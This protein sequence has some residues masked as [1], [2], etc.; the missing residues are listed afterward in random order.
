MC[1]SI[2]PSRFRREEMRRERH[3]DERVGPVF[4]NMTARSDSTRRADR[5]M[6]AHLLPVPRASSL[7]FSS[8]SA[9]HKCLA[10]CWSPVRCKYSRRRTH[11]D[12]LLLH[13]SGRMTSTSPTPGRIKKGPGRRGS[14]G[15]MSIILW[16]FRPFSA[17]GTRGLRRCCSWPRTW[18]D[19]RRRHKRRSGKEARVSHVSPAL[20]ARC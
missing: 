11:L 9:L 3:R 1:F 4:L 2:L 12:G 20:E 16:L 18:L 10:R 13:A 7:Q 19:R 17:S 15:D 5:R 6:R 8:V 14:A